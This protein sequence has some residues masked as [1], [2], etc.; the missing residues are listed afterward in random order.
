MFPSPAERAH[1]QSGIRLS[2]LM[3]GLM[4]GF[5]LDVRSFRETSVER[6][7]KIKFRRINSL[8]TS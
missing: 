2:A 3:Y 4:Y 5:G 6:A 1:Q 8:E 7:A